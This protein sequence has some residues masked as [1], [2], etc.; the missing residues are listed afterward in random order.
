MGDTIAWG[1]HGDSGGGE[2]TRGNGSG[3]RTGWHG[4][5]NRRG[6]L[7]AGGRSMGHGVGHWQRVD[8]ARVRHRDCEA[9]H[10]TGGQGANRDTTRLTTVILLTLSP[11]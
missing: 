8:I 10:W 4:I 2:R 11:S 9:I 5:V 6:R 7:D 1:R 3:Y